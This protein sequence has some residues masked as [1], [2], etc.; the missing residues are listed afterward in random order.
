MVPYVLKHQLV[1]TNLNDSA[2]LIN[3][4]MKVIASVVALA[5]S[6]QHMH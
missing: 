5:Y 2:I 4:S 6:S 1:N 3:F